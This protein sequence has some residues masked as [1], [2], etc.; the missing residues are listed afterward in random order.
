[1]AVD[2]EVVGR[3]GPLVLSVGHQQRQLVVAAQ[4][5][6]HGVVRVGL[7]VDG[8]RA[9]GTDGTPGGRRLDVLGRLAHDAA[10]GA[11]A[12]Q[13]RHPVLVVQVGFAHRVVLQVLS[14]RTALVQR[15]AA[16]GRR[17]RRRPQHQQTQQHFLLYHAHA[18]ST[19]TTTTT[20]TSQGIR[21]A[22]DQR[23]D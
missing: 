9:V 20:D 11:D 10:V 13:Q 14:Q 12:V 1:V 19:T 2:A 16:G 18:L 21:A 23:L 4:Q 5:H 15:H 6:E 22:S 3:E 17:D 8:Q 7:Q